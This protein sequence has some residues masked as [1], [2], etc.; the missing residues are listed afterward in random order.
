MARDKSDPGSRHPPLVSVVVPVYNEEE[1]IPALLARL[2]RVLEAQVEPFEVIC[3]NDGSTDRSLALLRREAARRPALRLVDL[4]A[5]RGQH[6]ALFEGFRASRGDFVVTLDADL[7]NPPEEIPRITTALRAGHDL[8][9]TFR[10]R[11]ADSRFRAFS[12]R[13]INRLLR[14]VSGRRRRHL[15]RDVGCMLRGFSR[16]L[17][18]ALV[19]EHGAW[20]D[21]SL[22]LPAL[23]A[24]AARA[25]IE[26][27]VRHD[28]RTAGRSKYSLWRLLRLSRALW[29]SSGA[30]AATE[31]AA[32]TTE[33]AATS[34]ESA[35]GARRR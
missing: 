28:R 18:L 4:P 9:S 10:R 19:A 13:L 32:A 25:P 17:V 1:S 6:A 11:R 24:A 2:Y 23:A 12:S 21:R 3:V 31:A 22:F 7:Q 26:L 16:P 35:P 34:S 20:P 8:V 29:A 14:R 30:A 33:A 15:G 27:G 5:N